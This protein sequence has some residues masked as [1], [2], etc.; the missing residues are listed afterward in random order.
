MLTKLLQRLKHRGKKKVAPENR[1]RRHERLGK[2]AK[3]RTI[4]FRKGVG[5][6]D[7]LLDG[8]SLVLLDQIIEQDFISDAQLHEWGLESFPYSEPNTLGIG[9]V[10]VARHLE[11]ERWREDALR[12]VKEYQLDQEI[13][14]VTKDHLDEAAFRD[15]AVNFIQEKEYPTSTPTPTSTWNFEKADS[16]RE[17]TPKSTTTR[18]S[19]SG[20]WGGN[21]DSPDTDG[22][23]SSDD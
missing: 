8:L 19:S 14:Q 5:L 17:E 9:D 1:T 13:A 20:G 23:E 11:Q 16:E 22:Y 7:E 2:Y 18:V 4:A 10:E 12:A 21:D 3:V 15:T 6:D